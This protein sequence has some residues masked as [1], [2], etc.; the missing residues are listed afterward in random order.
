MDRNLEPF[1]D[2]E[3]WLEY[4]IG[5]P[6]DDM[7]MYYTLYLYWSDMKKEAEY[8]KTKLDSSESSY[9]SLR[10]EWTEQVEEIIQKDNKI[11]ELEEKLRSHT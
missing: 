1:F 2:F 5:M 11:R 8:Y 7:K 6:I 4:K 3:G 9:K 10:E